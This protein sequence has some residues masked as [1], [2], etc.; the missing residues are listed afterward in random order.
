MSTP[1]EGA[2]TRRSWGAVIPAKRLAGAKS[3]LAE[4]GDDVRRELVVAFL[5]DTVSTVLECRAVGLVVVV[6]DDVALARTAT[7][8]GAWP[9]P[10]GHSDDLNASLVQGA[11]D[12]L[13]RRPDVGLLTVCADLPALRADDLETWLAVKPEATAAVVADAAGTG[14]TVLRSVGRESYAPAFGPG[15]R[16]AHVAG[17]AH[18]LTDRAP[19]TLR[20]DVDTPADL[21]AARELGLGERT[22]WVLT[23]HGL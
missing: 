7:D 14:T 2:T 20:R 4:L 17:G 16:A 9:I 19:Q 15:S 10:D 8:L 3:R 21:A 13:R 23:R 12:A 1:A 22:R 18:D 6:T 5:H 11:A